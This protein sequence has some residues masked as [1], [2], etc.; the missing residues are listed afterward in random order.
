MH[1][2]SPRPETPAPQPGP[3][4]S[5]TPEATEATETP[6]TCEA[7]EPRETPPAPDESPRFSR[8][9]LALTA[10]ATI[11]V[12]PLASAAIGPADSGQSAHSIPVYLISRISHDIGHNDWAF[13]GQNAGR[14][15]WVVSYVALG[16]FWLIIAL[17][18]RTRAKTGSA[19]TVL[20]AAATPKRRVR[21]WLRVLLAAWF[22]EAV[23]GVLTLGAG[24]YTEWTSTPLGPSVLHVADLCSPWWSCVA[25]VL[26]VARAE[27]STVALRTILVYAALLTIVLLVPLPGPDVVKVLL[28]ALPAAVPALLT[29]NPSS[30]TGATPAASTATT[31]A[32]RDAAVAG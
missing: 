25:A 28:L 22:V 18:I 2:A 26:V 16:L 32:T 13:Q 10:A 20:T 24:V 15:D 8:A 30:T 7:P 11:A 12:A 23:T 19:E 31:T 6:E 14:V 9:L 1:T 27:R 29:P 5:E 17:W 21:L 4:S 3:E